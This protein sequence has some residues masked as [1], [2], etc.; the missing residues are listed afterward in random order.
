MYN[1][2]ISQDLTIVKFDRPSQKWHAINGAV[3]E[4]PKGNAGKKQAQLHALQHD[5][6]HVAAEIKA[7]IKNNANHPHLED[8]EKRIIKAGFIVRDKKI[9]SPR[10]IS[11]RGYCNGEIARVQSQ[12]EENNQ[13]AIIDDDS[14]FLSCECVD[15]HNGNLKELHPVGHPNRPRYGAPVLHSGQIACKHILAILVQDTI[16]LLNDIDLEEIEF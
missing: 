16:D 15:W 10:F 2:S 7:I 12:R 6:P 8:I 3:A 11:Q 9:F 1:L 14:G 5:L 4:F 13:Y